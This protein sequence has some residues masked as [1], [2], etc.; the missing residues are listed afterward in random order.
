MSRSDGLTTHKNYRLLLYT[1]TIVIVSLGAVFAGLA[2]FLTLPDILGEGYHNVQATLRAIQ[3]LLFMRISLLYAATILLVLAA[4]A[5][6]HLLYSHR[7]AGPAYRLA[8]DA[9]KIA[10]GDLSANVRLRQCDNLMDM[11][12]SMN[13]VLRSY[14]EPLLEVQAGLAA[15]ESGAS[16]LSALVQHGADRAAMSEAVQEIGK[17]SRTLAD[18]LQG[19]R[20]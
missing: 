20:C 13:A 4:L 15:M 19:I 8:Q 12:D 10:G 17:S 18:S 1:Y 5:V 11:A 9:A 2:L 6:L 7:I 3:E 16:T 14:R